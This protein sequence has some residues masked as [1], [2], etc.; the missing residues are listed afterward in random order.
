MNSENLSN[1]VETALKQWQ[2]R[3]ERFNK[4][5]SFSL[6][7]NKPL[8]REKLRYYEKVASQYGRTTNVDERFAL[9]VLAQERKRMEK[10]LYPNLLVRLLRRLLVRPLREQIV[11]NQERRQEE[12][13][14]QSVQ[15]Q[16][17]RAGFSGLS[18]KV[19]EQIGKELPAF[20][21][22][23]THYANQKDRL[24]YELS[25]AKDQAG[26]YQFTG[27]K[28][29][30]HNEAKPEENRQHFFDTR[31]GIDKAEA[32]NLLAGRAINSD[33]TWMQL[34]FNDRDAQGNY[35]VKEFHTDYG[36][37]IESVINRLPLK[38]LQSNGEADKLYRALNQG[39]RY[40][41][42]FMKDGNEQRYYIEANPQFKSVN[43]YD[44]HSRK[45]TLDT[46][47]GNKIAEAAKAAQKVTESQ[48]STQAKRNGMKVI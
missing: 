27:Y 41:V 4:L 35:R 22:P 15:H 1:R 32:Y 30:L 19:T 44:E 48:K 12:Q 9:R 31:Y 42:S 38:E 45:V 20:T 17:Q 26:L 2:S 18:Q 46:A 16:L 14:V 33:G 21:V 39:T 3:E 40:A 5:F 8:L 29:S 23:L 25:F 36:F 11:V 7:T 28:I 24:D 10:Q 6:S 47:L 37:K 13:N 34:D 43:I